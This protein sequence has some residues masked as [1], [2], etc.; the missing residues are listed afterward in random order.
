MKQMKVI[1][2]PRRRAVPGTI[3]NVVFHRDFLGAHRY[4][5]GGG[6]VRPAGGDLRTAVV[7][8]GQ[9]RG[10]A[11]LSPPVCRH[12]YPIK[13]KKVGE[14]LNSRASPALFFTLTQGRSVIRSQRRKAGD[15]DGS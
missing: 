2:I 10:E 11:V 15:V 14:V 1:M 3:T 12:T 5:T 4:T 9:P 7:C 8:R 6:T 13:K